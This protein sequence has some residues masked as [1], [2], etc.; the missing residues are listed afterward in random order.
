[1]M[2]AEDHQ[3]DVNCDD[4]PECMCGDDDC[5]SCGRS[6]TE[7]RGEGWGILGD[8]FSNNDPLWNGPD[9]QIVKCPNCHGSGLA[10]DM[11]YW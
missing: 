4:E 3:T 6:C 11:T 9:G 2:F 5:P 8:D 1:M 10:K 7:C